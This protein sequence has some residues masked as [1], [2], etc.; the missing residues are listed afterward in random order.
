M[1]LGRHAEALADFE[2]I[3]ELTH[4]TKHGELFRAFHAL[5]KARLGDL[6]ALALL[7]DQVRETVKAGAGHEA[8][9]YTSG[10]T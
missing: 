2:E 10:T 1:R 8:E 4:G 5:T 9:A 6:S 7:G 3:V